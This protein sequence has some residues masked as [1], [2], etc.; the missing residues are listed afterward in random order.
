MGKNPGE[1]HW[2]DHFDQREMA[3][4]R[5]A[6]A[7]ADTYSAAGAPGH[8]QFMLINKLVKLLDLHYTYIPEKPRVITVAW[9]DEQKCWRDLITGV[10][11]E[12]G[13]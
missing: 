5:H 1:I 13:E 6:A 11:V 12:L 9:N 8:G 2:S 3:Q 10:K 4:I 7:Y